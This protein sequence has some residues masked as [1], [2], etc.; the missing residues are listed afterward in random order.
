MSSEI[1]PQQM[2]LGDLGDWCAHQ[3]ELYFQHQ[4]YDPSYCFELFRRAIRERDQSAW[5]RICLQYQAL[6]AGWVRQHSRFESSGEDAQYFVNGAFGK[7]AVSLT[8]EKFGGFSDIGSLLRYLKLC[9]HSVIMDYIRLT[10]QEH[11]ADLEDASKE[12]SPEPSP[13]EQAMDRSEQQALWDLLNARLQ[14]EKEHAVIRGSFVLALKPQEILE[15]F[16]NVFTDIDEIYRVKQNIIARL[17]RD[18][19]F[20]KFLVGDD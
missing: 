18:P 4:S 1:K 7:I 12:G 15:H 5:E 8:P 2:A 13:E 19:E 20:R 14:D 17:R 10:E 6:V 16:R 11:F 3:T 9:V